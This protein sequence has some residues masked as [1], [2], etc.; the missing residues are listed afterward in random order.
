MTY[1]QRNTFLFTA[2][3]KV[4]L[5]VL[6]H[7]V[8]AESYLHY[9]KGIFYKIASGL[10]HAA[11]GPRYDILIIDHVLNGGPS[12]SHTTRPLVYV[13]PVLIKARK[14]SQRPKE[15]MLWMSGLCF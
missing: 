9:N 5:N 6:L 8:T 4:L 10:L 1:F 11:F 2:W 3:C 13:Y 14:M 12:I 7:Y 15:F